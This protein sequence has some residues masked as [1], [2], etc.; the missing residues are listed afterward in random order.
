VTYEFYKPSVCAH[1]LGFAKLPIG[2]YLSDL[3]N[4]REIIP[5]GTY[6]QHLLDR[7]PNSTTIDLS[8][9]RFAASFLPFLTSGGRNGVITS[10]VFPQE[11]IVRS[12]TL[13]IMQRLMR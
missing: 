3:I 4:P 7:V 10:S 8:S 5:S 11:S 6:Y 12:W 1:Q 2:L 13:R 9:W